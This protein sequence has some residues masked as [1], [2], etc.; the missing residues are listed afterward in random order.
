MS[1]LASLPPELE[2]AKSHILSSS[3]ISSL[4][5]VFAKVLH[6]KSTVFVPLSSQP[7]SALVSRSNMNEPGRPYNRNNSRGRGTS[8]NDNR[9]QNSG[10]VVCYYCHETRP[11]KAHL[12]EIIESISEASF[13]PCCSH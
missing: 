3:K 4:Q 8:N 12:Q 5:D 11:Y 10:G 7:N 6:T 9:S 13:S 2:T 1:F